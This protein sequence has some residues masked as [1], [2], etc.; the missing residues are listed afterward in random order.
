MGN[1]LPDN[2]KECFN[3][4]MGQIVPFATH[5]QFFDGICGL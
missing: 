3:L 4:E 1:K 5:T 2:I